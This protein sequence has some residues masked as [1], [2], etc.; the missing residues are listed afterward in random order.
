MPSSFRFFAERQNLK[1]RCVVLVRHKN[2][3]S[4]CIVGER[5]SSLTPHIMW[6]HFY[7]RCECS[8]ILFVP[9]S[10]VATFLHKLIKTSS[11]CFSIRT[12]MPLSNV[13][14]KNFARLSFANA[15]FYSFRVWQLYSA[16]PVKCCTVWRKTVANLT[17][18]LQPKSLLMGLRL[19]K[20][21]CFDGA[22]TVDDEWAEKHFWEKSWKN[23]PRFSKCLMIS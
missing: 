6:W 15:G 21:Y 1:I 17:E 23:N 16:L 22:T 3:R 19:L 18:I 14:K 12:S 5:N 2:V 8:R 7:Y 9:F 10:Y 13:S 20:S 4:F 11:L